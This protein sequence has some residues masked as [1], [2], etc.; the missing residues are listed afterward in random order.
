MVGE[1]QKKDGEDEDGEDEEQHQLSYRNLIKF[2]EQYH[3]VHPL[4]KERFNFGQRVTV[5]DY[6]IKL[7]DP[8]SLYVLVAQ[9]KKACGKYYK[10]SRGGVD[11]HKGARP[12]SLK[13]LPDS[14]SD[15]SELEDEVGFG[16]LTAAGSH[17]GV[18]AILYLQTMKTF[19]LLFFILTI[20]N[21]PVY[22]IYSQTT[23]R[24]DY[25]DLNTV[26]QYFTFGNLGG[27]NRACSSIPITFDPTEAQEP[28]TLKC[29]LAHHYMVEVQTW[30]F[31]YMWDPRF[32]AET[33]GNY[34]CETIAGA[35]M[36][37]EPL[38]NPVEEGRRLESAIHSKSP[39]Q[40]RSLS[41]SEVA[42]DA[43]GAAEVVD[44]KPL[45]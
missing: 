5:N 21:L 24:N 28:L 3:P 25:S 23:A 17:L 4:T 36:A 20:L 34:V 2:I 11:D 37:R 27:T 10:L 26:F 42:G 7:W 9:C 19:A 45:I 40:G 6:A 38:G 31:L 16:G 41:E 32:Q 35:N 18:G 12:D 43:E 13:D 15:S 14:P 39:F 22:F 1:E 44:P 30:G 29:G 8:C 33:D